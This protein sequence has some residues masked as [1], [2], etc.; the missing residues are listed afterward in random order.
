MVCFA[1]QNAG[2]K[3]RTWKRLLEKETPEF[4]YLYDLGKVLGRGQFGTTR[5]AVEKA[6]KDKYAVKSISKRKMSHPDDIED[7]KREIEI[8][9]HLT[10][11][12]NIVAFKGAYED[13]HNIHLVMELCS[14]GE[15]FDRYSLPCCDI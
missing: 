2:E 6:T 7:V 14:G 5:V 12:T 1:W 13:R 8:L 15:L 11:H 3:G 9:H 4:S 10:G